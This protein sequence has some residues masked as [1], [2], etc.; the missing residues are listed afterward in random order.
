M[1]EVGDVLNSTR[2]PGTKLFFLG[3]FDSRVTVLSQQRR[4]LNLVDAILSAGNL[5]RP[6]GRVA[7]VGGGVAG[8]TAAAAFA[9]AAPN[10]KRIDLFERETELLHLQLHS[11]RDLHPFIYDWPTAGSADKDAGLPLLNW[12]ASTAKEVARRILANFNS[13]S[14]QSDN[15]FVHCA[16]FAN[17]V[18]AN[19]AGCRLSVMG[20]TADG[21][22]YDL[23]ILAIGYGYER[24]SNVGRFDSYWTPSQLLGPAGEKPIIFVSG[25]GDGGLVDFTMAAFDRMTHAEIIDMVVQHDDLDAIKDKLI[26]IERAAWAADEG[27]FDILAQ[28]R[29]LEIPGAVTIN[30]FDRLRDAEVWLHTREPQIFRKKS[31]ILNRFTAFLAVLADEKFERNKIHVVPAVKH[32]ERANGEIV[33]GADSFRPSIPIFRFGPAR[34]ANIQPFL[35]WRDKFFETHPKESND[36]HAA[37]PPLNP[38]AFARF[39]RSPTSVKPEH[40][41][42]APPPPTVDPRQWLGD[43]GIE[44][45][46]ESLALYIKSGVAEPVRLLLEAGIPPDTLLDDVEPIELALRQI[47]SSS[48][49]RADSSILE[50]D[51]ARVAVLEALLAT[52]PRVAAQAAHD[53]LAKSAATRL[54]ALLRAGVPLNAA[55]ESGQTLA[56]RAMRQDDGAAR[57]LPGHVTELLVSEGSSPPQALGIWMLLWAASTGRTRL[58]ER[59]LA[60][61]IPVDAQL[62]PGLP[63]EPIEESE[64]A[65]W[66]PGGTAMHR[67]LA[68]SERTYAAFYEESELYSSSVFQ[69]LLKNGAF[70]G[71]TD[72]FG[73]TPLHIAAQGGLEQ[74]AAR[75]LAAPGVDLSWQDSDGETALLEAVHWRRSKRIA[76]LLIPIWLPADEA[77]RARLLYRAAGSRDVDILRAL[78]DAGCDPNAR[79]PGLP[80]ALVALAQDTTGL[81]DRTTSIPCLALLLERGADPA[82]K[83]EFSRTALHEFAHGTEL[84]AIDRLLA[85]GVDVEVADAN[86]RT[87][88]MLCGTPSIA[89]RL[90]AAGAQPLRRDRYGYDALDHAVIFGRGEVVA[91]LEQPGRTARPEARMIRALIDR[92]ATS[93]NSYL[94]AGVPADTIGPDG[95]PVLNMAAS[96]QDVDTMRVL[97]DKGAAVEGR[98]TDGL[99]PLDECLWSIN[100]TPD[101]NTASISLLLERGATLEAAADAR[102][103]GGEAAVF[104]GFLWWRLGPI[105]DLVLSANKDARS[106][107]GATSLMIAAKSGNARQVARL[108]REGVNV[109]LADQEGLTALHYA[110]DGPGHEADGEYREKAEILVGAEAEIDV[111]DGLGETPLFKAVRSGHEGTIEFLLDRGADPTRRNSKD[112]TIAAVALRSRRVALFNR[113]R[114][115]LATEGARG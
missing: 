104:K 3:C 17:G 87:P 76:Q 79:G 43:R 41:T 96:G 72:A 71:T 2:V 61:G 51:P 37:L 66:W 64:R 4:A 25:N 68:N 84:E 11:D 94:A 106:R 14:S 107:K 99:A 54:V 78:L 15:L 59:L 100:T 48:R 36:Y 58:V 12:Q 92:D 83:D 67:L 18:K 1:M 77:E 5:V 102:N 21:G 34:E 112:E 45:K 109:K 114:S 97:L 47:E 8:V 56:A 73:R 28:Y 113:L 65:F 111:V 70:S 95:V 93:V 98:G 33:L 24:P 74:A 32:D 27:T 22:A 86:G 31:A 90:L 10:L 42:V 82:L 6:N 44:V 55:D 20:R 75:L 30:V 88:L 19:D 50:P 57:G 26:E 110:A 52:R 63:T 103:G 101:T 108:V 81:A 16:A 85:A 60:T 38:T 13:I 115:L 91:L 69:V 7:I 105:A 62:N 29:Q 53:A 89:Q 49:I 39:S 23:V 80:V 46:A 9:I 40:E 35:P